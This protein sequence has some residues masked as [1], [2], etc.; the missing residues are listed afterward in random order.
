MTNKKS[1]RDCFGARIHVQLVEDESG[2]LGW[3]LVRDNFDGTKRWT[4][5]SSYNIE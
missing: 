5:Y 4:T 1:N 3:V 2:W